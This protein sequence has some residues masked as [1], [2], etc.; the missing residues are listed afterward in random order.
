[1]NFRTAVP[2]VR[3]IYVGL[4]LDRAASGD[5]SENVEA[6]SLEVHSDDVG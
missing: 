2:T 5:N 6:T 4:D 1:M 3:L